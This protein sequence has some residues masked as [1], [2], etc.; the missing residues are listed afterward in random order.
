MGKG[1]SPFFPFF[2]FDAVKV[3]N[4][5]PE[6]KVNVTLTEDVELTGQNA[7]LVMGSTD[8]SKVDV[9]L[10]LGG[11]TLT[12]ASGATANKAIIGDNGCLIVV[13]FIYNRKAYE[14]TKVVT[15][16]AGHT[17]TYVYGKETTKANGQTTFATNE[18]WTATTDGVTHHRAKFFENGK[19]GQSP[20]L[21]IEK[22]VVTP[23]GTLIAPVPLLV[24]ANKSVWI[25]FL[26]LSCQ[27]GAVIWTTGILF[28]AASNASLKFLA[29]PETVSLTP[30]SQS[31]TNVLL[32]ASPVVSLSLT[33]SV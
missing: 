4:K 5:Y 9:N 28:A 1:D 14:E 24:S 8:S 32:V 27:Y 2:I 31:A 29:L 23:A 7:A 15:L 21:K 33:Y 20:F 16:T 17:V 30:H 12:F 25:P 13:L 22:T 6:T 3:A 10:D 26:L 18:K 19:R 11:N